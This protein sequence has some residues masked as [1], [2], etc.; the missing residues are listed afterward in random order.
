MKWGEKR[1]GGLWV[2]RRWSGAQRGWGLWVGRMEW[3]GREN[4]VCGQRGAGGGSVNSSFLEYR[5][6]II[7]LAYSY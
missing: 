6:K 4:G 5:K 3:V 2:G 1:G 7:K